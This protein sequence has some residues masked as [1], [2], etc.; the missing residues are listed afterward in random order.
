MTYDASNAVDGRKSDQSWE[1]GKCAVSLYNNTAIWWVNLIT[2][3]SIHHIT[4]YFMTDDLQGIVTQIINNSKIRTQ[5]HCT[6]EQTK[7]YTH[8]YLFIYHRFET[9]ADSFIV[10]QG[11]FQCNTKH[12]PLILHFFSSIWVQIKQKLV[13]VRLTLASNYL[14]FYRFLCRPVS[15][16]FCVC[17]QYNGY[18]TGNAVFQG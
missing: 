6:H 3:Y 4:I 17:L 5:C 10:C 12:N 11:F 15:W 16:I 7:Q 9:E 14:I 2:I 18:I 13:V 1:G 8:I